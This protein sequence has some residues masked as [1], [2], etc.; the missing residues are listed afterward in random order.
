MSDNKTEISTVAELLFPKLK[1]P[2]L[3]TDSAE[4]V[5]P[6]RSV[7]SFDSTPSSALQTPS[8]DKPETPISPFSDT[9]SAG[10]TN[11]QAGTQ[12]KSGSGSEIPSVL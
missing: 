9:W 10:F 1:L 11:E 5:F 7:V 12:Q 4:R 8:L 3:G 2:Q 6:V